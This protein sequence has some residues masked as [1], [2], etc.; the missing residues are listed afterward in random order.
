M[1]TL[2]K[3]RLRVTSDVGCPR[4]RGTTRYLS[5]ELTLPIDLKDTL[6]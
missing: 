5:L 2:G 3:A 6:L 1:L 4:T